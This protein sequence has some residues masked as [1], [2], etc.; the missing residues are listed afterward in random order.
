MSV[1]LIG[2]SFLSEV[3]TTSI[4]RTGL[5][6]APS[7][8]LSACYPASRLTPPRAAGPE[9]SDFVLWRNLRLQP[10]SAFSRL[11]PVHRA[12]L[13][14]AVKGRLRPFA[15]PSGNI[16]YLRT[17]DG[18]SRRCAA[19]ADRGLRHFN[20]AA[21]PCLQRDKADASGPAAANFHRLAAKVID[22]IQCPNARAA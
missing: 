21:A 17:P 15:K 14:G 19:I 16:R 4:L 12:N 18:W 7:L 11:S 3:R 9:R 1:L 2:S 22:A 13:E 5:S 8:I 6:V 10:K 20:L